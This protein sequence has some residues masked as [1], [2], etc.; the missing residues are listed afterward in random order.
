MVIIKKRGDRMKK[1]GVCL[2]SFMVLVGCQAPKEKEVGEQAT[3][4]VVKQREEITEN[5]TNQELTRLN[6]YLSNLSQ[7][8]FL[9]YDKQNQDQAQLL[10]LGFM[11]YAYEG[12][13]PPVLEV[14]G[15]YYNPFNYD[16]FTEKLN[17]YFDCQLEKKGNGEWLFQD[18]T[19][20]HPLRETGFLMDK[21]TQVD[22]VFD[23]GDGSF[24]VEGTIYRFELSMEEDRYPQYVQPKSTW[25]PSMNA[26][27]IGNVTVTFVKSEKLLHDVI[28]RYQADYLEVTETTGE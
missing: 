12:K 20:Y 7:V 16:E 25:T 3:E 9:S 8:E 26:D 5:L 27:L 24:L 13:I 4:E 10:N 1:M 6:E 18:E 22:R 23:N 21:V 14:D 19:F 2:L 28:D 17:M 15:A 11:L